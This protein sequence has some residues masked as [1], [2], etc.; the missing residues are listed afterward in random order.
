MRKN[1][2]QLSDVYSNN[3]VVSMKQQFCC[4]LFKENGRGEGV[5]IT[6]KNI[7]LPICPS[8]DYKTI[9]WLILPR[10]RKVTLFLKKGKLL[11][12]LEAVSIVLLN[13]NILS[14]RKCTLK[15]ICQTLAPSSIFSTSVT[16]YTTTHTVMT[17]NSNGAK[18][19]KVCQLIQLIVPL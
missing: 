8:G 5:R 10:R 1:S 13:C 15:Q 16:I 11:L 19:L 4:A 2:L 14:T 6:H 12:L 17:S 7:S 18:Y 9:S 3:Q